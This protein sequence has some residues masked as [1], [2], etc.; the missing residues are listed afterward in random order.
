MQ[1]SKFGS[2]YKQHP[3]ASGNSAGQAA[4]QWPVSGGTNLQVHGV[5]G[6]DY[7]DDPTF[8]SGD[9]ITYKLY[10]RDGNNDGSNFI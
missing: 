8:S 2:E 1:T 6:I 5:G 3:G 7:Q 4:G 9:K 10:L